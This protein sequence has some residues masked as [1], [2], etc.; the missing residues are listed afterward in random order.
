[1]QTKTLLVLLRSFWH[2]IP[3]FINDKLGCVNSVG[4]DKYKTCMMDQ[5]RMKLASKLPY[6]PFV[7]STFT[8]V[9]PHL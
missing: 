4:H 7:V 3:N 5:M 2:H 6:D 8:F 1:M 9:L